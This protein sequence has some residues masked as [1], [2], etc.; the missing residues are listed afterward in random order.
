MAGVYRVLFS[1]GPREEVAGFSA[2]DAA[3]LHSVGLNRPLLDV[4]ARLS[5]G[6]Q[7]TDVADIARPANGP[8]PATDLWPFLLAA[9]LIL[10]PL[11][12]FL[13]RRA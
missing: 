7:L 8:G 13:R 2:P 10:L 9:A 1:Q 6:H 11:D 12:V 5:G 4:L 3:A